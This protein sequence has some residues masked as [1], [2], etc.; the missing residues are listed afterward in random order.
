MTKAEFAKAWALA[1]SNADLSAVDESILHGCGLADFA[2][3]A[4]TLAAVAKLLRWQ[5]LYIL[6][7]GFDAEELNNCH[8]ILRRKAQI[9][10]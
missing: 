3:V 2:P 8:T 5:C 4:T 6:G 7:D 9:V 10:G 1:R